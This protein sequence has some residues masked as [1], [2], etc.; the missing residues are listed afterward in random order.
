MRSY[1]LIVENAFLKQNCLFLCIETECFL[2]YTKGSSPGAAGEPPGRLSA[3]AGKRTRTACYCTRKEGA[4]VTIREF[5]MLCGISPATASR[6]FSGQGSI[7]EEKRKQIEKCVRETGYRP[8]RNYRTRRK[9]N[10]TIVV[11][12][13]HANHT[14][15]TDMCRELGARAERLQKK[16]VFLVMDDK[17]PQ[18]TLSLIRR[19]TPAGIILLHEST[20][21]PISDALAQQSIPIVVCG[22]LPVGRRFS[23]VHI[24]DMLAAYDGMNYL[25]GLGHRRIG[26]IS[27]NSSAIS[28]GFQR[29]TGC[30]KAMDDAGLALADR[31]IAHC[32]MTFA[33]GYAGAA[34]L[35]ERIPE[36]TAIFAFS[37]DTAAGA[38]AWLQDNGRCVPQDVSVLGFDDNSLA[39]KIR[40]RLT[41]VRQPFAHIAAK[42]IGRLL[43]IEDVQDI[44][45]FTLMH[46]IVERDSCCPPRRP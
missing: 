42:S 38:V 16:L 37:D 9:G 21:D 7:S 22:A 40:P 30:R 27:D 41:T 10:D 26:I 2:A 33:D 13:P 29:I 45:S 44:A 25:I 34:Q 14:F 15:F 20:E 3:A 5:A 43:D 19:Y 4:N 39:V 35:L 1:F 31:Q 32:G 17:E 6:Y 23:S 12:L 46:E 36:L 11:L 28:S 24:D 8:S 18:N